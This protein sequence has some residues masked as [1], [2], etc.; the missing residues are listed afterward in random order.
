MLA[1]SKISMMIS[2]NIRNTLDHAT[3]MTTG[4]CKRKT[5]LTCYKS[6]MNV[7]SVFFLRGRFNVLT[8]II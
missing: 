7:L 6:N 2:E 8:R 5:S 4:T 1:G 3:A